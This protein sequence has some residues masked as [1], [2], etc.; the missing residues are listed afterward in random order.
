MTRDGWIRSAWE[1]RED[2]PCHRIRC[3]RDEVRTELSRATCPNREWSSWDYRYLSSHYMWDRETFFPAQCDQWYRCRSS[4]MSHRLYARDF[5]YTSCRVHTAS[6]E[7]GNCRKWICEE[8]SSPEST[9]DASEATRNTEARWR[10]RCS[11]YRLSDFTKGE[12]IISLVIHSWIRI[13]LVINNL[14]ALSRCTRSDIPSDTVRCIHSVTY[15]YMSIH[16]LL[17]RFTS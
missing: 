15:G 12:S 3:H 10:S 8:A 14:Y 9:H 7:A 2:Y 4:S 6:G 11:R 16:S 17:L 13:I 1:R 5:W